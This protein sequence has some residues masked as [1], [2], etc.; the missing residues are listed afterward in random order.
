MTEQKLKG[1]NKEIYIILLAEFTWKGWARHSDGAIQS[2]SRELADLHSSGGSSSACQSEQCTQV[3]IGWSRG[4]I[5]VNKAVQAWP[6]LTAAPWALSCICLSQEHMTEGENWLPGCQTK[7]KHC[8]QRPHSGDMGDWNLLPC[9]WHS[10]AYLIIK[11]LSPTMGP[12]SVWLSQTPATTSQR[13]LTCFSGPPLFSLLLRSW[14]PL[15]EDLRASMPP[16]PPFSPTLVPK[17]QANFK[18]IPRKKLWTSN[19][20]QTPSSS[21]PQNYVFR[22][23]CSLP[24]PLH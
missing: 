22:S 9:R 19:T 21:S 15:G 18:S 10:R 17:S 11:S 20:L 7:S 8:R 12:L 13:R 6:R 1:K 23:P 14:L 5:W 24:A 3:Y 4:T 2:R 16:P